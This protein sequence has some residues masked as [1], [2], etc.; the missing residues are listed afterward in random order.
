[1]RPTGA[2]LLFEMKR[3]RRAL[4]G[5][6]LLEVLVVLLI[7]GLMV[8]MAGLNLGS[9]RSRTLES[10]ARTLLQQM[11]L[12]REE[13]ILLDRQFG[14]LLEEVAPEDDDIASEPFYRYRWLRYEDA[15]QRWVVLPGQIGYTGSSL[16]PGIDAELTVS[17]AYSG[18]SLHKASV[19]KYSYEDRLDD[20]FDTDED[21]L[22]EVPPPQLMFLSS[23]EISEF[24]LRLSLRDGTRAPVYISADV[25]DGLQLAD[26]GN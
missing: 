24:T 5:F 17:D 11:R 14:L 4:R 23:G 3:Y 10:T 26:S 25:I 22:E 21:K 7:V 9:S 13:A 8:S 18:I 15:A 6:S 20:N 1:M 19:L 2:P 12:A 16:P